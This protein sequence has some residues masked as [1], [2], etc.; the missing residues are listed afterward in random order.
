MHTFA[1]TLASGRVQCCF[2]ALG[3]LCTV[4]VVDRMTRS[5]LL[6][7]VCLRVAIPR[8]D[9]STVVADTVRGYPCFNPHIHT[10]THTQ[11]LKCILSSVWLSV[12]FPIFVPSG[13]A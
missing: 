4:Q 7:E 2:V 6:R 10:R 13:C 12:G 11:I 3:Y 9:S 8:S 5:Y 1:V